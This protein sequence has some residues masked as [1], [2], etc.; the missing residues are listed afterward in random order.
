VAGTDRIVAL[1]ASATWPRRGSGGGSAGQC[2]PD[3]VEE[4]FQADEVPRQLRLG[5][6]KPPPPLPITRAHSVGLAPE[7]NGENVFV[8]GTMVGH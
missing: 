2:S 4:P 1:P 6:V 8:F 5:V 7:P 3:E